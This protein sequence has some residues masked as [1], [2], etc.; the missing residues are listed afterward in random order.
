M[1][2]YILTRELTKIHSQT[3][4]R[5]LEH[6]KRNNLYSIKNRKPILYL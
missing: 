4:K 1:Q 6:A 3:K 5:K 2:A